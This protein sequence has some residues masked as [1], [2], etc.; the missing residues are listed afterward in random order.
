[1]GEERG[2]GELKKKNNRLG[3]YSSLRHQ[4]VLFFFFFFFKRQAMSIIHIYFSFITQTSACVSFPCRE[5]LP[6]RAIRPR[7]LMSR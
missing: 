6:A 7:M 2:G 1:M 5:S 3:L 4:K